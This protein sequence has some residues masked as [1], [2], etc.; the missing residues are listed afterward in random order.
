MRFYEAE[1][2]YSGSG[3]DADRKAM[4]S[5]LHPEIVLH[6][7]AS[8]PYGGCWRGR[9]GFGLWL[10][11]FVATWSDVTA[12][13]PALHVCSDDVLVSTVT[14]QATARATG[15]SVS[16]PMCQV[17]RFADSLPIEW[18]NFAWDTAAL[19]GKLAPRK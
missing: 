7:P 5:T 2:D 16:M 4:L 1:V 9:E 12:V 6:Q 8:L 18:R 14:M 11:A 10:D 19:L 17:I 13:D 15:A 3:N